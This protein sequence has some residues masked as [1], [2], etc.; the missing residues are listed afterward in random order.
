MSLLIGIDGGGTHSTAVAA[1]GNGRVVAVTEGPGLNHHNIGIDEAGRRL[2]DIVRRL[3]AAAGRQADMICAGLAGLDAP[4]DRD[5]LAGF[6]GEAHAYAALDLQSD[7]Y[8][9]LMGLTRGEPGMIVICGTGSIALMADSAGRQYVSGGWGYL[10]NDAGSG[11]T[12][13]RDALLRAIDAWEGTAPPT[14]LADEAL[15]FFQVSA[16]RTIIEKVYAPDFTPDKMAGFAR[17]VLT[18]AESGDDAANAILKR[19]M[20]RLARQAACLLNSAPDVRLVGLYGGIFAHSAPARDSFKEAL[21]ALAPRAELCEP[22]Y[23]PELGAVIHLMK[24]AGTLDRDSLR[25]LKE[26][27]LEVRK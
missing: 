12:L 6:A 24:K 8:A 1:D 11:Y 20:Q 7:C 14:G 19:N 2:Y 13:A 23:P 18:L 3:E 16:P 26:T 27:Y 4:A 9:A 10:L 21:L 22:E 25:L 5:T 15:R 17:C